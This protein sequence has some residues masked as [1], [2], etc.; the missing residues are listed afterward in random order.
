MLIK[1]TKT[2]LVAVEKMCLKFRY[3]KFGSFV[4]VYKGNSFYTIESF[5]PTRKPKFMSTTYRYNN[6]IKKETEINKEILFQHA[7]L[8]REGMIKC[9]F[10]QTSDED[11]P[12]QEDEK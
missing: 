5:I 9:L 1:K 3:N 7:K 8:E 11:I 12:F 6:V 2:G 10:Q 4:K